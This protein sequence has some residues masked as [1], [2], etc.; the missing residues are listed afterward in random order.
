[1]GLMEGEKL[2]I[3][4]ANTDMKNAEVVQERLRKLGYESTL[5][6]DVA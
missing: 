2:Y 4:L 1:M 3:L 6:E 5:K